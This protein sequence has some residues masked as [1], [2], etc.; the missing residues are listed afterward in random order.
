MRNKDKLIWLIRHRDPSLWPLLRRWLWSDKVGVGVARPLDTPMKAR[1]PRIPLRIRPLEPKDEPA[2]SDPEGYSQD[3]AINRLDARR[4]IDS[5]IRTIYVAATEEGDEPT[6]VQCL[7]FADEN[8]RLDAAFGG[9]IPP[10]EPGD[11]MIDFAFTIEKYRSANVMPWALA[12]LV[13]MAREA[14]ATR[15]VTWLPQDN[16]A[17][18]RFLRRVG[19]SQ[20]AIRH[21]RYR[22][23][24][25][26][27]WFEPC[28]P[29]QTE[30][31]PAPRGVSADQPDPAA[32]R[33]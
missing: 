3:E 25:R 24:R 29:A 5:R 8:H 32:E 12:Q 1:N 28:A 21:E 13:E 20:F 10:L 9:L 30:V 7:V 6:F 33:A 26:R 22:L 14:G 19:F 17:M 27:I 2:F 18:N 15:M 16:I 4:L 31:A 23:G 11:A